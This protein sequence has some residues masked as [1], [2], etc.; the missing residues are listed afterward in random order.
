VLGA[1]VFVTG[2]TNGDGKA[3]FGFLLSNT[4]SVT[5]TDFLI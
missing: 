3:D 2:D 1:D 5:V 4:S